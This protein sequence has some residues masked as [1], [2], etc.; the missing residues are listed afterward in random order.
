LRLG[1]VAAQN[2]QVLYRSHAGL[3]LT[4][5]LFRKQSLFLHISTGS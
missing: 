1:R 4:A 2:A 3:P 5:R